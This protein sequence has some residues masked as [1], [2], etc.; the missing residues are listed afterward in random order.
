VYWNS[1]KLLV[2]SESTPTRRAAGLVRDITDFNDYQ[3]VR[4]VT[5]LLTMPVTICI[6]KCV[7]GNSW[8]HTLWRHMIVLAAV[9]YPYTS[10]LT[11]H[12]H[13]LL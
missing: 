9:Y 13:W 7:A 5:P 10:E 8:S 11:G 1:G 2:S 6:L 3:R 4:I 12:S